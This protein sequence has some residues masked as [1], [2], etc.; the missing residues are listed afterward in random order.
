MTEDEFID[1]VNRHA[2]TRP[3]SGM[4][5]VFYR[6]APSCAA[7]GGGYGQFLWFAD[8]AALLEFLRE[9][10]HDLGMGPMY[11]DHSKLRQQA[12]HFLERAAEGELPLQTLVNQLNIALE[13]FV[14]I[15]WIGHF[16]DLVIGLEKFPMK[17]REEFIFS[18]GGVPEGDLVISNTEVSDFVG[19]LAS[20]GV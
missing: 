9:H 5:G 19:F 20:Y 10:V 16:E 14:E 7:L 12:E 13:G 1:L 6:D 15:E 2:E 17:L 3:T 18:T 4:S 8:M 11:L